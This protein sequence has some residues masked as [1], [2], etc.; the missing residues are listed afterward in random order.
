MEDN[1]KISLQ[2]NL[3]C[4]KHHAGF[5]A[6]QIKQIKNEEGLKNIS[7]I[8]LKIGESQMDLYLGKLTPFELTEITKKFL[9]KNIVFKYE[10]YKQ[11]LL[12]EDKE[13]RLIT[14][15]DK[16]IWTLR[17]GNQRKNYVHIHPGR[18]SLH[19]IRVRALTL[20]TA[21]CVMAYLNIHKNFSLNLKLVNNVRKEFLNAAPVK[22]L[23]STSGL[24][25][26]LNVFNRL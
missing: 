1:N 11:W 22:S 4:W 15:P 7:S 3:N 24:R 18:Y 14:L 2:F 17:M 9:K 23:S 12:S 16:S 10:S 21:I 26:L 13:Y 5:I 19:T 6:K 20:K 25:R 8:L